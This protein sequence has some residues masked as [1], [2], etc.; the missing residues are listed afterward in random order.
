MQASAARALQR[1]QDIPELKEALAASTARELQVEPSMSPAHSSQLNSSSAAPAAAIVAAAAA[2]SPHAVVPMQSPHGA[3]AAAAAAMQRSPIQT[4]RAVQAANAVSAA[5]PAGSPSTGVM[6][7]GGLA[8]GGSGPEDLK[9]LA[10]VLASGNSRWLREK[11]A[12][13]VEQLAMDNPVACR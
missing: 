7:A 3:S 9:Q 8:V 11:A 2:G 5:G 10:Q 12:A 4:A 6:P 1:L 13:A